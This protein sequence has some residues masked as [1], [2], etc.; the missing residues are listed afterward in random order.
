MIIYF[1]YVT[2]IN[3]NRSTNIYVTLPKA[4]SDIRFCIANTPSS[5]GYA[6][7]CAALN[8]TQLRI[9]TDYWYDPSQG[10]NTAVYYMAVGVYPY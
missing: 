5:C 3:I 10:T 2:G 7:R 8:N 6:V 4:S 9:Y 1:G